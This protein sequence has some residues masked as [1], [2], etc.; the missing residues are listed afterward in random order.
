VRKLELAGAVEATRF[1]VRIL[2]PPRILNLWATERNLARDI[3]FVFRAD[4]LEKV[5][6]E[7]PG[8]AILTAFSGWAFLTG[9]RPAE[10]SSVHFYVSDR[11]MFLDWFEPRRQRMRRTNPNVFVLYRDDPHLISASRR[12]IAPVPQIYVDIYSIGG[13]EAQP[14]LRDIVESHPELGMW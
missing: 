7:L 13:P 6:G 4:P 3:F 5:E 9:S 10:Y 8:C 2:S 11:E 14:Y 12:G 1:G